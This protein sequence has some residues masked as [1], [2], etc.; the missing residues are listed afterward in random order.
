M[1][2]VLCDIESE[3]LTN[4]YEL[5]LRHILKGLSATEYNSAVLR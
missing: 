2:T 4:Y 5:L 3:N 1:E